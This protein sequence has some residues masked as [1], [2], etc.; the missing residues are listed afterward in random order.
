[1]TGA[2]QYLLVLY[3]AERR[4]RGPVP[5]GDV[6]DAVDR[7][8]SA[9]TEMLQRLEERGLVEHEPYDGARLTAEGRETA[10]E[11]YET[12]AVLSQFFHEVLDLEDYEREAMRLAG[13]VSPVV[14]E[15]LAS[16]L[17]P[18]DE[19]GPPTERSSPSPP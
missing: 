19:P 11:L 18:D 14:A 15:R 5:S 16:T 6:A 17:F 10:E 1:M 3:T 2:S 12:Y 9:T 7:S 4:G 13:T 8:P